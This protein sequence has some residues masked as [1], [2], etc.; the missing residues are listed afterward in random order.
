MRIGRVRYLVAKIGTADLGDLRLQRREEEN[1][2][3]PKLQMANTN[4]PD[5]SA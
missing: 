3:P 5:A 2:M 4:T 1:Q